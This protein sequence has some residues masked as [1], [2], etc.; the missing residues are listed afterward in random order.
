MGVD[1]VLEQLFLDIAGCIKNA[2]V[3]SLVIGEFDHLE[4]SLRTTEILLDACLSAKHIKEFKFYVKSPITEINPFGKSF[5]CKIIR[6]TN[7]TL[8]I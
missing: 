7:T 4:L 8:Y 6:F 1:R 2:N 5:G 3:T